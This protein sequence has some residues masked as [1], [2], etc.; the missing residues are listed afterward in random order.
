MEN[1]K[2]ELL[3]D[4]EFKKADLH[5]SDEWDKVFPLK[6]GCTPSQG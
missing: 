3:K 2:Q 4:I 5:L 1:I 6:S